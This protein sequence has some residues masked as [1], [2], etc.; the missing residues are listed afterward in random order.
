MAPEAVE[1]FVSQVEQ[2]IKS[3]N[4]FNFV[5]AELAGG[6]SLSVAVSKSIPLAIEQPGEAKK[7]KQR[8]V[9]LG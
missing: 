2:A 6:G 8:V 3:D 7:S 4:E 9:V 1:T 5:K